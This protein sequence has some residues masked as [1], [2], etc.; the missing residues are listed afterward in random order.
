MEFNVGI[1]HGENYRFAARTSWP[2]TKLTVEPSQLTL[3][4]G[5]KSI[6]FAKDR[7]T[8]LSEYPGFCWLFARGILIEHAIENHPQFFVFWMFDLPR[9][10]R[11]L[12][13][14]GFAFTETDKA[15]DA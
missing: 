11:C 6:S 13:E 14:N 1:I 3:T 4:T 12:A 2:S 7:I 5:F 9:V 8:R 10:K 15:S